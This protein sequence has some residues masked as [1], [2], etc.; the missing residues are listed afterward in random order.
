VKDG[1]IMAM[2]RE[3]G[4]EGMGWIFRIMPE[5]KIV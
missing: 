5:M 3:V 1:G 2:G 4:R